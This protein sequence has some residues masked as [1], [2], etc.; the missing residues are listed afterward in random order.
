[1]WRQDREKRRVLSF[2][3]AV[4]KKQSD[5]RQVSR[6]RSQAQRRLVGV[7]QRRPVCRI[8]GSEASPVSDQ[9]QHGL[10]AAGRRGLLRQGHAV[11]V[12]SR[13]DL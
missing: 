3:V 8:E 1:M 13:Q 6:P 5:G 4:G 7:G 11:V 10:V 2:G 9:A 12:V